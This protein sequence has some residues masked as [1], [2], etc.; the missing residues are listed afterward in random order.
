M[1]QQQIVNH[2]LRALLYE[3]TVNPKPGLVDPVSAGPHPDMNAFMFIDSALSLEPYFTACA[4]AGATYTDNDLIGLF[5]QI[6]TVGIEA[7]QTMFTA[8]HG[9]NTHKGAV[10]S[11][12]VLVTAA[13]YQ[14]QQPAESLVPIVQAMLAGLTANDFSGLA[15]KDPSEL[16]AGE[17]QY[18]IYGIKGIR[19]EAEAGYPTVMQVALPALKRSR[20][21]INQR[22]L[23]TLMA[24]VQAT[25]DTNLVKRANDSHVVDWAH[26]Q[27]A[28]YFELGG[29]QTSEGMAFLQDLN[30]E[31][32]VH[33]YSLGGSADLLILTIFMGLEAG[34]LA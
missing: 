31:F 8:T 28:K 17:R 24:I 32:L 10:F 18:L 3:V 11:L 20:G 6:R 1:T 27:A 26:A 5:Q 23:D 9:V 34:I 25:V 12:G 4:S 30:Q 14:Q 33:N 16:T 29:S 13:A 15:D 7:E 21:T 19:G 2:A 22:L